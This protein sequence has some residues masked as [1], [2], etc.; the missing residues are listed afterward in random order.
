[1]ARRFAIA[2]NAFAL[3]PNVLAEGENLNS[4]ALLCYLRTFS[5]SARILGNSFTIS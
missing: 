5:P 1:M 4:K 2:N 3:F